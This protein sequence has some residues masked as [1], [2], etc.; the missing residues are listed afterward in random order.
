MVLRALF[1]ATTF[2]LCQLRV[3][4]AAVIDSGTPVAL[5]VVKGGNSTWYFGE[6][7]TGGI[8]LSI[9]HLSNWVGGRLGLDGFVL[10]GFDFESP[11]RT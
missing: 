5:M 6:V 7:G 8:V 1:W 9:K 11:Y 3:A 10:L 2:S 4:S